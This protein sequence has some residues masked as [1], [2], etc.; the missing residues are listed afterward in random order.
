MQISTLAAHFW[1]KTETR[2][3][4]HT[5]MG[6]WHDGRRRRRPYG[7]RP[8]SRPLVE[9]VG[10]LSKQVVPYSW[11]DPESLARD[12]E[13]ALTWRPGALDAWGMPVYSRGLAPRTKPV[14]MP[15]GGYRYLFRCQQ[16]DSWRAHLYNMLANVF[17]CRVCLGLRYRSQYAGRRVDASQERLDEARE[18]LERAE[19]AIRAQRKKEAARRARRAASARLRRQQATWRK[20]RARLD[21]AELAYNWRRDQAYER[22]LVRVLAWSARRAG[23]M[24]RGLDRLTKRAGKHAV[25]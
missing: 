9:D 20:R 21:R 15:H 13:R 25:A 12:R 5:T 6:F 19:A 7:R 14:P 16:C 2:E 23:R 11:L 24:Q 3:R 22:G 10:I 18:V 4:R 17:V 8:W 1:H